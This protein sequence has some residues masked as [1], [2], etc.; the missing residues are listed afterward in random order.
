MS[1]VSGSLVAAAIIWMEEREGC[2]KLDGEP[3]KTIGTVAASAAPRGQGAPGNQHPLARGSCGK[4]RVGLLRHEAHF[5][6]PPLVLMLR[7]AL[8]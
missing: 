2:H 8:M 3:L 4:L 5:E 6:L 7:T 1:A